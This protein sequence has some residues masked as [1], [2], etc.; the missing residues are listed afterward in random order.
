MDN[1]TSLSGDV[2]PREPSHSARR[3]PTRAVGAA[4]LFGIAALLLPLLDNALLNDWL[5]AA[6]GLVIVAI[7]WNLASNAGLI[8]LGHAAFWGIGSYTAV[9]VANRFNVPLWL[10]L[11]PAMFAGAALGAFLAVITGRLRGIF[12]AIAALAMA[13]GLRVVAVMLPDVTGGGEGMY[14]AQPLQMARHALAMLLIAGALGSFALSWWISRSSWHFA[15]RAMRANEVAAQMLGVPPIRFRIAVLAISGALA[16]FA[17]A[18]TIWYGGFI[19][20]NIAFDMRVTILAQIAPIL[21]G[22]NTLMGPVLGAALSVVLSETTRIWLGAHGVSLL[23]YG[24]ALVLC[25]LF[26]PNGVWGALSKLRSKR[27]ATEENR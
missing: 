16:S 5:I 27:A 26:L 15:F 7:S 19:D 12:F 23:V 13:E 1:S 2:E 17:G 10:A 21:G 22:V 24:L 8:S 25:I 4:T 9:L 11:I 6:A 14:V 18:V 3:F 20:P